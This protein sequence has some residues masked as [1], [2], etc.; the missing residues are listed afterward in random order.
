[1]EMK[2]WYDGGSDQWL[3][4]GNPSPLVYVFAEIIDL[5]GYCGS[6]A[7]TQWSASV[8]IVDIVSSG[9]ETVASALDSCGWLPK[10]LETEEEEGAMLLALAAIDEPML[11]SQVKRETWD[12]IADAMFGYGAKSPMWSKDSGDIERPCPSGC[13]LGDRFKTKG[14]QPR[15]EFGRFATSEE[16]ETCD[17][18]GEL[19]ADDEDSESFIELKREALAEA[20]GLAGSGERESRLDGAPVNAIGQTAR[21]FAQ[22]AAGLYDAL[23]RQPEDSIIRS[24]Y[25]S[26]NRTLDG[27]SIPSD[28]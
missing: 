8:S 26:C 3:W 21:E 4:T 20:A 12:Q 13:D 11:R 15:D 9:L 19:F 6:D 27:R 18:Y 28:I 16:C 10:D 24:M 7:K 1:M 17:G 2:Q 23:R 25:H 22:G 5:P 14:F